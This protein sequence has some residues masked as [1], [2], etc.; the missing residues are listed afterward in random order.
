MEK[1]RVK[2]IYNP[3]EKAIEYQRW[4]D[5][6]EQWMGL[7]N[8]SKLITNKEFINAT[9][10]HNACEII[11]ELSEEYNRGG[12]GLDILFEGTEEDYDDLKEV[13]EI[14]YSEKNIEIKWGEKYIDSAKTNMPKIKAIFSELQTFFSSKEYGAENVK[15]II[16]QFND[17]T[18]PT[19]P[20]CVVGLYSSGKSAF[21]NALIGEEILPSAKNPT[22][23]RLF[24]IIESENV[25]KICFQV[26]G[27]DISMI[28]EKDKYKI[29]G[30]IEENLRY[31]LHDSLENVEIKS[32][33]RNMYHA[34]KEINDYA[35]K[36]KKNDIISQRIDVW[37]PFCNDTI[38]R[39]DY[40]FVIYDTPGA[41]SE[42]HK[43]HFKVLEEAL[44]ERTNGLPILL[45]LPSAGDLEGLD[46]LLELLNGMDGK[47]DLTNTIRVINGVE[48]EDDE[49]F[50]R[51]GDEVTTTLLGKKSTSKGLYFLSA[52][53]GLGSRKMVY[54]DKNGWIDGT[55]WNVF[56][57]SRE[58]FVKI[59]SDSYMQLYKHNL[60][61]KDRKSK[62][63]KSVSEEK[64]ERKLL[65]IN[66][67][68]HCIEQ[69]IIGFA[70]KYALY[71]KCSQAQE[72]L[73]KAIE[74]TTRQIENLTEEQ[75]K[76][77]EQVASKLEMNKKILLDEL[78]KIIED[79]K[80]KFSAYYA[81]YMKGCVNTIR[82]ESNEK[83][84]LYTDEM[85]EKIK[86]NVERG[87]RVEKFVDNW[88][89]GN[90]KMKEEC[91]AA[92]TERSKRYCEVARENLQKNC[93]E[94]VK[95]A[96][97]LNDEEKIYL[98]RFIMDL[99]MPQY[100]IYLS[101][102][103]PKKLR[104]HFLFIKLDSINLKK[105]KKEYEADFEDFIVK[106]SGETVSQHMKKF[107]DWTKQLGDGLNTKMIEM[108][109]ALR[110]QNEALKELDSKIKKMSDVKAHILE[111]QDEV[112]LIFALK[113]RKV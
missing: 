1:N 103:D 3:Y 106:E 7:N 68:L 44:G 28:F 51:L 107:D 76:I 89:S 15:E 84:E 81:R 61:A 32:L 80:E 109:P 90:K 17:A 46:N 23:A 10:Q 16:S 100:K 18:A 6:S 43:E 102:I 108:N 21:I 62:Y 91:R 37:V 45:S 38:K 74:H 20:I 24:K 111:K 25:G 97:K 41:G 72:Y 110:K 26:S 50:K 4:D 113:E 64:D 104:N 42:S 40:D 112:R 79:E 70:E 60:M 63:L 65:Y 9:I 29:L 87:K 105:I 54:N 67:G 22:T 71:N 33:T 93:C 77:K 27:E 12:I 69:E 86:E 48:N 56:R 13:V 31:K 98:H 96:E 36:C 75:E 78:G 34:L 58:D 11:E 39:K 49:S 8:K 30:N 101:K 99:K 82:K 88:P 94:K 5:E 83:L 2:I 95:G 53:L 73:E 85:W 47:L 92:L 66:S 19:I 57:K 59:D 52:I 35:D 14:F 55:Y